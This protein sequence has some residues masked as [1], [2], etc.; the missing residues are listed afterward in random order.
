VFDGNVSNLIASLKRRASIPTRQNLFDDDDFLAFLTEE[1]QTEILPTIIRAREDHY[2]TYRDFTVIPSTVANPLGFGL[3]EFGLLPFGGTIPITWGQLLQRSIGTR[4]K[5]I[6]LINSEGTTTGHIPRITLEDI[7]SGAGVNG[8]YYQG[9][10]V[11]FYPAGNYAGKFIRVW[12]YRMPNRLVQSSNCAKVLFVNYTT[13][14]ITVD[15]LPNAAW[16]LNFQLDIIQSYPGYES[17][18]DGA[19]VLNQVGTVLTLDNISSSISAGDWVSAAGDAC[20]AQIPEPAYP[21]LSQLG[22]IKFLEAFGRQVEMQAAQAKYAE[23]KNQF[24]NMLQPR[25][26]L[27]KK[28]LKTNNGLWNF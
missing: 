18:L 16:T 25:V 24:M 28:K 5:D 13:K 10:N 2:L 23:M 27:A 22:S 11:V 14:E 21:L 26:E 1:L 15:N 7:S 19:T 8:F 17:I 6:H 20:V 12:Y 4:I 3:D 9:N